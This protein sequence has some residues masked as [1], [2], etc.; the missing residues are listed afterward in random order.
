MTN[1]MVKSLYHEILKKI[2]LIEIE[3]KDT[4]QRILILKSQ[5]DRLPLIQAFIQADSAKHRLLEQAAV[6]AMQ[7][8]VE[9]V[10]DHISR[11]YLPAGGTS[12]II[13]I[14]GELARCEG[15]LTL[16]GK[17]IKHPRNCTFIER[18]ILRDINRLIISQAREYA[19]TDFKA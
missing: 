10:L 6:S 8:Q 7:N 2:L 18:R 14:R 5:H 11:F 15:M 16:V 4:A 13:C 17:A 3:K 19:K 12:P 9:E 1:E